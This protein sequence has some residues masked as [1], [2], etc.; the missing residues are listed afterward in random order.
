VL[1]SLKNWIRR[2]LRRRGL[3][4]G[5][6]CHIPQRGIEDW[7]WDRQRGARPVKTLLLFDAN[8]ASLRS[9]GRRLDAISLVPV[10]R[11]LGRSP[12]P[13]N[14][15]GTAGLAH[16]RS[17]LRLTQDELGLLLAH[18]EDWLVTL[19]SA[20]SLAPDWVE[21]VDL[22]AGADFEPRE[23]LQDDRVTHGGILPDA[24]AVHFGRSR[25]ATEATDQS[26]GTAAALLSRALI[27][28]DSKQEPLLFGW[29]RG[30]YGVFNPGAFHHA[31]RA[32]LLARQEALPWPILRNNPVRFFAPPPPLLLSLE[33]TGNL[34]GGQIEPGRAVE[35]KPGFP[36]GARAEDFR[37]FTH[38]G[39]LLVNHAI[40]REAG[41]REGRI[42]PDQLV[43]RVGLAQLDPDQPSLTF[44]GEPSLP[45]D[46]RT[47][48]KNWA[49]FSS[50]GEIHLIYSFQPFRIFSA[51]VP[52]P[53]Q[54]RARAS[55]SLELPP[56]LAGA[57]LRNSINP[58][59]Y[60]SRHLLHVVHTVY[61]EKRYVFWPV[62]L[63]RDSLLP[64]RVGRRPI[65]RGEQSLTYVCSALAAEDQVTF[66]GGIDDCA[67]GSWQLARALLEANWLPLKLAG[68]PNPEL[69][70]V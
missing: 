30:S 43:T 9:I 13:K 40:L 60:D 47:V 21:L 56:H 8:P 18:A 17:L 67:L 52:I 6:R 49:M 32:F 45:L 22:L 25:Q 23:W 14:L 38:A 58:V 42:Q 28:S 68:A 1:T 5:R 29:E 54:Y 12:D 31:G 26:V 61:A 19:P 4:L 70:T 50:G 65:L 57:S 20:G 33:T 69:A 24:G 16:A 64:V 7:L 27:P 39:C 2:R 59:P 51:P 3:V 63:D 62:L 34:Q 46:L 48:E 10:C 11:P 37:V 15:A 66:F 55:V 41:G 44:L 36:H 53:A 35:L